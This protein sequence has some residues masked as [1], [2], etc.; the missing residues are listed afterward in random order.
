MDTL[1]WKTYKLKEISSKIGD[2]LHGTP[3]YDENGD[4]Y[5]INGSNLVNG[6]IDINSNTKKVHLEEFEK[7]K[8]EL[9]DR[10][11]L[12]GI[13]GTIGNL[14]LYNGEKCILGKSAAYII[15]AMHLTKSL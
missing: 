13:N 11:I 7:Y 12:I 2:G 8:K 10:T 3:T 1:G 14:A 4:Y 9:T 5:F 6:K 15:L